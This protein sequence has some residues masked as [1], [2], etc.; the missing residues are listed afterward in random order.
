MRARRLR[1]YADSSALVKLLVHER[2]T[3]ALRRYLGVGGLDLVTSAIARVEVR[4]AVTIADPSPDVPAR[5]DRL[6][7]GC[8]LLAT[9]P[10]L[11]RAAQLASRHVRTLDAIHLAS[12]ESVEPHAVL[13][14]DDR[15]S[16]AATAR[17]LT[18]EQPGR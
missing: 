14:Y 2:E 4:R 17:G 11:G 5:L 13:V 1:V 6:L 8:V 3:P 16:A 12:A 18:V 9:D 10:V 15:L 7:R